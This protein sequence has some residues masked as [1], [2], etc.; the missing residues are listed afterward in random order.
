VQLLDARHLAAAGRVELLAPAADLPGVEA[1]R[2]AE[3]GEPDRG[4]VQRVQV[5]EGVHQREHQR[6]HRLRAHRLQRGHV[7][8]D[9]ALDVLHQVERRAD[10]VQVRAEQ[11]GPRGREAGRRERVQDP[12]LPDHVVGGRQDVTERRPAQHPAV[13]AVGDRVREVG[14]AAGEHRGGQLAGAQVGSKSVQVE[15]ARPVH[16]W[17]AA[18]KPRWTLFIPP[19]QR[20]VSVARRR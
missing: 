16:C 5:G 13:G 7:A 18:S 8:V 2:A 11:H 3:V 19:S 10:H 6:A 15:S 1:L 12:V 4:R 14:S 20:S 17:A 9:R